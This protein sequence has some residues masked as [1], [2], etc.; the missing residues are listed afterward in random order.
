MNKLIATG[1]LVCAGAAFAAERPAD[2]AYGVPL[3]AD[4]KEAIYEV[5]LPASA[6]R[7]VVRADLADVRV[8]N[9]AGEAVPHAWRPRRLA[10]TEAAQPVTLTLF[11]LKAGAGAG[12]DAISIRVR[13]GPGGRSSIDVT[14]TS[15]GASKGAGKRT[16]G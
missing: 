1:L 12:V 7:G 5:V 11:P 13:R 14:S 2:F 3:E 4:G 15:P 10:G 6:Y 16:V 8:F 9:G